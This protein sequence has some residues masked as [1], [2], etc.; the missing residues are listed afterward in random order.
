LQQGQGADGSSWNARLITD[1]PDGLFICVLGNKPLYTRLSAGRAAA[2]ATV[3]RPR[4]RKV[5]AP[6]KHGAG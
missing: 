1:M 4:V 3:E 2:P 6:W 5:R